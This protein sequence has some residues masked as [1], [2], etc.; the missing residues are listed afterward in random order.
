MGKSCRRQEVM[1]VE[2]TFDHDTTTNGLLELTMQLMG[3]RN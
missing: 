2:V 3:C 1:T